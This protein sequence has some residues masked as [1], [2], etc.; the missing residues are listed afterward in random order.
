MARPTVTVKITAAPPPRTVNTPTGTAVFA[1]VNGTSSD[2]KPNVLRVTNADQVTTTYST[3][4][5]DSATATMA[6]YVAACLAN[7]APAVVLA[8]ATSTPADSAAWQAV[9][10]LA[11][12]EYGAVAQVAIPGVTTQAARD[13]LVAHAATFISRTVFLDAAPATTAANLVTLA[14]SY[15]AQAASPR[16]T[17]AYP[18][19]TVQGPGSTTVDVP[20]SVVMIGR[21][22]AGDAAVGH[23]NHAPAGDQLGRGAGVIV[24]GVNVTQTFTTAELDSLDDAG[25]SVI[26]M[27][28]GRP[29]I[30][31]W[32]SV[33]TDQT[34]H[35]LNVGRFIGQVAAGIR[36]IGRQFLFTPLDAITFAK[37]EASI[38]GYLSPL[39]EQ[40]ALWTGLDGSK[41][42]YEVAVAAV[43]NADKIA[44][45]NLVSST[46]ISATPYAHDVELRLV[47]SVAQEVPAA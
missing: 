14:A 12:E 31:G 17:V 4:T 23:T 25:V 37:F 11:G 15:N 28:N 26:R 10:A 45:R 42:G 41:D 43:N 6:S 21:V 36:Q 3:G 47:T 20:A 22:G 9:L 38:R 5:N 27:V 19:V 34:F 44:A 16:T 18:A 32:V 40:R 2:G 8:R 35:Q 24:G 30:M 7:G 33:A 1:W 39:R 29:T 13:A 46:V